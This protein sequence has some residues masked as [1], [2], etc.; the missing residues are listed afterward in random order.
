MKSK[1]SRHPIGVVARAAGVTTQAIRLWEKRGLLTSTRSDGGQRLFS[2]AALRC[3]VTLAAKSRRLRQAETRRPDAAPDAVELAS[4]G[5]RIKRARLEHGQ[6]QAEAAHR[7]GIS[8]SFLATV[9]RGESGVSTKVLAR[10]ADAFSIPMSG[11]AAAGDA[12][13]RIMRKADRPRTL[14]AGGVAWEELAAPSSH[15]MEPALL[16]VPP[17]QGSGG[18]FVRPGEAFVFVL[19]GALDF[20]LGD[21]SDTVHLDQGDALTIDPGISFSWSNRG[22]RPAHCIWVEFIGGVRRKP[23]G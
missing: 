7:I 14:L 4:T 18:V 11:F 3:A 8:R 15:D 5:M 1:T 17:G 10:M 13:D 2:E 9:E 21:A 6:S 22:K 19:D 20:Q 23:A 16:Y 12:P